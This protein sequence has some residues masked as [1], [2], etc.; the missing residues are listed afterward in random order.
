MSLIQDPDEVRACFP[1]YYVHAT[2][3][4]FVTRIF[5]ECNVGMKDLHMIS[6]LKMNSAG[7]PKSRTDDFRSEVPQLAKDRSSWSISAESCLKEIAKLQGK[8]PTHTFT[9][10]E[11]ELLFVHAQQLCTHSRYLSQLI[12]SFSQ[13]DEC[14]DSTANSDLACDLL[15]NCIQS[16]SK[17]GRE[18]RCE[19]AKC[20]DKEQCQRTL[21][22]QDGLELLA[23]TTQIRHVGLR[24]LAVEAIMASRPSDLFCWLPL[25]VNGQ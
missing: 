6:R 21:R 8:L 9:A 10:T 2:G 11:S 18:L 15:Y 16:E 1:C 14:K 24:S 3:T 5:K 12:R 17:K 4:T 7:G 22:P 19:E 20:R 25:L 13:V 23:G